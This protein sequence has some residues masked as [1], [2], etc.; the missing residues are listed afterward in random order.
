[1]AVGARGVDVLRLVLARGLVVIGA[2][3]A[4]GGIAASGDSGCWKATCSA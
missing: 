3:I 1:M 2:G 4:A